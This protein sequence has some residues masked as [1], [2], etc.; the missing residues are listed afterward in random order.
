MNKKSYLIL[1]GVFIVL[2]LIWLIFFSMQSPI[3]GGNKSITGVVS[4][5]YPDYEI[6]SVELFYVDFYSTIRPANDGHKPTRATV[7][8]QNGD[9]VRTI[10]LEK[11]FLSWKIVSDVMGSSSNIE[12]T[13]NR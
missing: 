13:L 11:G 1:I 4:K 3:I 6:K 8:I 9:E 12:N 5:A 7:T 10:K 2:T